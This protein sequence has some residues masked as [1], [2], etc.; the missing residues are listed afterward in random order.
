LITALLVSSSVAWPQARPIF[1]DGRFSDWQDLQP[2]YEDPVGDNGGQ[3]IDLGRIWAAN[4]DRF[5]FLRIEV[6]GE[7]NLQSDNMLT[8][9]LDTDSSRDTGTRVNGIGAELRW[10]FGR[11]TGTFFSQAG[12]TTI[13]FASV[14]L[15]TLPTVTSTEFEIALGRDTY[16]DG[17]SPLFWGDTVRIVLRDEAAG[18][19]DQAPAAGEFITYVFDSTSVPPPEPIAIEKADERALRVLTYNVLFDGPFDPN[20]RPRFSRILQAVQPDIICFQEMFSHTAEETLPLIEEMLPL[21]E[22]EQWYA[23]KADVGNITVSRFPILDYWQILPNSRMT[24]LLL[25]LPP[26]APLDLLLINA[27]LR[28]CDANVERQREADA[29]AAFLRDARQPGGALQLAEGTPIVIAG[30]LNLVGFR[31]QQQT[32]LTGEIVDQTQFGPPAPPDWDGT[33]LSDLISRQ[34]EL[35]MAYTWRNDGGSF[36]PGRLDYIIF[37]DSV[38]EVARH[39]LLY[40]PEMS[41]E[42]LNAAGLLPDDVSRASDHLPKVADF[43]FKRETKVRQTTTRNTPKEFVLHPA[44]PN[45]FNSATSIVFELPAQAVVDLAIFDLRGVRVATLVAGV[46]QAGRHQVVW[47]AEA[48]PSGLYLCRLKVGKAVEVRKLVLSK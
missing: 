14:R 16:P 18:N 44:F 9:Y 1:L 42:Y 4:D 29:M 11:R 5:L 48:L 45:P 17:R 35:R 46:R 47:N 2:I 6:G 8:L 23:V 10:V 38:L 39:F 43:V 13:P 36:S 27:H 22:G 34:T 24:A 37:T 32:I 19:A 15:R 26:E 21:P 25:D 28:C 3:V 41:A 31:Q 20:R 40:T 7:I 33:A 12:E 30:D